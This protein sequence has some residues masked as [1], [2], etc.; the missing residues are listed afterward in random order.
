MGADSTPA[1][2]LTMKKIALL[3]LL[4]AVIQ[5]PVYSG[6]DEC[7]DGNCD[8]GIGTGF[9]EEGKVYSGEWQGGFP[10]GFGKLT[11]SK[12]KFIEGQWE[13]GQLVDEK[14]P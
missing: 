9:T 4:A 12:D 13:K 5:L 1:Q 14:K 7:L 6:A 2:N 11:I 10:H 8:N 3:V